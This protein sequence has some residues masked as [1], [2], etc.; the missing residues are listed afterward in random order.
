MSNTEAGTQEKIE[1][2]VTR[3]YH[4]LDINCAKTTLTALSE[5]LDFPLDAQ[6]IQAATAMN[7]AGRFRGQCGLVEGML[8]FL[9]VFLAARGQCDET[10]VRTARNFAK[11]FNKEFGSISCRELRPGGFKPDDPEHMCA[12]LTLKAVR[13]CYDFIQNEIFGRSGFE[14]KPIKEVLV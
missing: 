8:M 3:C 11:K 13:F 10:A 9:G 7:G 4:T 14:L 1:A 2:V 12:P 5:L 6:V